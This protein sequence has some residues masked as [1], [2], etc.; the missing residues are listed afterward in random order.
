[1]SLASSLGG[2]SS[3]TAD[4]IKIECDKGL[5]LNGP[6][7][8]GHSVVEDKD[9]MHPYALGEQEEEHMLTLDDDDED[10][11]IDPYQYGAQQEAVVRP[12]EFLLLDFSAVLGIDATS[13]RSCFLM[14][15]QLMRAA[16]VK[17]RWVFMFS[18]SFSPP[19]CLSDNK[20]QY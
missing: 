17:V 19:Y 5:R 3:A 6:G 4:N 14:L 8:G 18:S 13:A 10:I 12:T 7:G 15:V 11:L 9:S 20:L 2:K 1:M 16:G